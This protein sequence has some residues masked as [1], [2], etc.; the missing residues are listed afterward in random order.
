MAALSRSRAV[1]TL[2]LFDL[3]RL[4]TKRYLEKK[5]WGDCVRI[6][7]NRIGWDLN[8]IAADYLLLNYLSYFIVE[9]AP[10]IPILMTYLEKKLKPFH[11]RLNSFVTCH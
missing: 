3:S 2:E 6:G 10:C 5:A 4:M 9:S 8:L 1:G 11:A 7:Q